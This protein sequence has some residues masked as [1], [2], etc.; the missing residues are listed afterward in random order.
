MWN[1]DFKLCL[2]MCVDHEPRKGTLSGKKE[3]VCG[4]NKTGVVRRKGKLGELRKQDRKGQ[5]QGGRAVEE[6]RIENK[7]R[8]YE[9]CQDEI[10]HFVR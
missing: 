3:S 1:L 7:V 4:D 2:C 5:G 9:K 8:T 6:G 10:H